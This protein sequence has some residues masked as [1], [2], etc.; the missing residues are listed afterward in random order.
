MAHS[1]TTTSRRIAPDGTRARRRAP[2]LVARAP[3]PE[4]AEPAV[5]GRW[6]RG[7]GLFLAMAVSAALWALLI[8]GLCV[9]LR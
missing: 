2:I 3:W 7:L 5:Q 4:T 6:P 8:W 9:L 1:G